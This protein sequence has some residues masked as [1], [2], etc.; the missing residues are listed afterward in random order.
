MLDLDSGADRLLGIASFRSGSAT[1]G[2]WHMIAC[3][4]RPPKAVVIDAL[5]FWRQ[6]YSNARTLRWAIWNSGVAFDVGVNFAIFVKMLAL[7]AQSLLAC[8]Y[9]MCIANMCIAVAAPDWVCV[10][11]IAEAPTADSLLQL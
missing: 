7:W 9:N 8:S 2:R 1:F 10:S 11:I 3:A 6:H 4:N 5:L